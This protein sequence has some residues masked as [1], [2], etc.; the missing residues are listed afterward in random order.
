MVGISELEKA[1]T[2]Y[3]AGSVYLQVLNS[4]ELKMPRKPRE[5]IFSDP[6]GQLTRWSVVRSDCN[7][8]TQ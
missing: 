7:F 3:Y 1:R 8:Q 4:S 6:L 2:K 5:T